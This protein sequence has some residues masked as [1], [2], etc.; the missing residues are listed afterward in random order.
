MFRKKYEVII[1]AQDAVN[2]ANKL[3]NKRLWFHIGPEYLDYTDPQRRWFRKVQVK[4]SK[5]ELIEVFELNEVIC[6]CFMD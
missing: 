1:E 4:A 3:A 2:T 5:Q 6:G